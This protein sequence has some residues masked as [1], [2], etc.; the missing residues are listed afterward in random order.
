MTSDEAWLEL[1]ECSTSTLQALEAKPLDAIHLSLIGSEEQGRPHQV[2]SVVLQL[3]ECTSS[4]DRIL[5][6]HPSLYDYLAIAAS[7]VVKSKT[8]ENDTSISVRLAPL[9]LEPQSLETNKT[10]FEWKVRRLEIV[11]LPEKAQI[12]LSCIYIDPNYEM[13]SSSLDEVISLALEG[14]LV[15]VGSVTILSTRY[16]VAIVMISSLTLAD[17]SRKAGVAFCLPS[18]TSYQVHIDSS[19][20]ATNPSATTLNESQTQQFE[21][22]IPGYESLLQDVSDMMSIS[23]S[24]SPSGVLL[25]GCAGVG[26]SRLASCLSHQFSQTKNNTGEVHWCSTQDLILLAST[27]FDLLNAILPKTKN[28]ALFIIDDL[29]LLEREDNEEQETTID[30]EFLLVQNS[31]VEAIDQLQE[32]GC[33]ILGIGQVASQLP[34]VLSKIG[35][36]EKHVTMLPPTQSQRVTIWK[37][38]LQPDVPDLELQYRWASALSPGT[39][40]CVVKDMVQLYQDAW[41]RAWARSSRSSSSSSST[42][43]LE[44]EDL[45]E[46]A[47]A[48]IPSQLSE[49]D[50]QKPI[51][52]SD[53]LSWVEIHEK[54]WST[55]GGYAT[56]QKR[57][58]R[59]VVGPWRRFLRELEDSDANGTTPLGMDPPPGV[60]FHGFPGCGKTHAANCLAASLG[61]PM[62]QVRAADVLDK[63]LGGSEALLRSLF[64][65]ARAASP[66]I[67]FM[68]EI[69]SIAS[70]RAAD[71]TNDFTARILSTFLNEMDGVSSGVK[72]SRVLVVA[73]T[74]RIEA[75]D[76]ALLRPGRLQEHL[77]LGLPTIEDLVEILQLRLTRIP[78]KNDVQLQELAKDLFK[79]GATCADVEGICREVCLMVL[80]NAS[81]LQ[82]IQV[83]QHD[84]ES[85]IRR[86]HPS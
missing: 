63:W 51:T 48:C 2:A 27:E 44:W 25:V 74:N 61:L 29:H 82:D 69:D 33:K 5:H 12:H 65:R 81:D 4:L 9:P 38:L 79:R 86:F 45:R 37:Y 83:S 67:L 11:D 8:T 85:A 70:N 54:S 39:T 18:A 57:V 16:G 80:R 40:G 42:P 7:N 47:R 35:R 55:F 73:C 84:F 6:V 22:T 17:N 15:M 10:N 26:K 28:C 49:L 56:I 13:S 77:F 46:A 3:V 23:G 52:A 43:P 59:H 78:L 58:F 68:D 50:V 30:V 66:C 71:D 1:A 34:Y 31:I 36:L 53:N 32:R 41:T 60:L 76:A 72:Q 21:N 75:L 20:I 24:A 62:I 14:R 64:A 19:S